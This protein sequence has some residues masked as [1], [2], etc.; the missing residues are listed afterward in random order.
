MSPRPDHPVTA[1]A[2]LA[3]SFARSAL[4][5]KRV[6]SVDPKPTFVDVICGSQCQGKWPDQTLDHPAACPE[7][8]GSRPHLP[9]ALQERRKSPNIHASSRGIRRIPANPIRPRHL[10]RLAPQTMPNQITRFWRSAAQYLLDGIGLM[11]VTF[12]CCG[13]PKC[14]WP[15]QGDERQGSD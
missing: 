11:L 10:G 4:P 9:S 7:G 6:R 2:P 1:S 3:P 15:W 12:V 5:R 13:R 14:I 8:A